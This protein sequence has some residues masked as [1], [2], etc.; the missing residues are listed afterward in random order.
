M[1]RIYPVRF[2]IVAAVAACVGC[3]GS[4]EDPGRF[5]SASSSCPDVPQAIFNQ[6]CSSTAGCHSATDKQLG[7]DLQSPDVA[8][9]LVGV[10]AMGGGGVDYLVDPTNPSKS[11]IYTKLTAFPPF[12]ARMP[13]SETPLDDATIACVLQWITTQ[14]S[15]GG[16][17]DGSVSEASSDD[18]TVSTTDDTGAP[19]GDDGSSADDSSSPA[20][21]TGAPPPVMDAGRD[22]KAPKEA[23]TVKD[24][25][26]P[27]ADA[28]GD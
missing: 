14:L 8:S 26:T 12:G 20:D 27:P 13:F 2:A 19:P 4:L 3:P 25:S 10:K 22:A 11:V 9:R 18:S 5:T 24:A 17:S 21:D 1:M 15:D 7:L 28:A 6:T 16:S 23:G